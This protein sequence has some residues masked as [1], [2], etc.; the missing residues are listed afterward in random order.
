ML[1]LSSHEPFQVPME[2]FFIGEDDETKFLNSAYYT[3][4]SLGNFINKAKKISLVGKHLSYFTCRP[5]E[6]SSW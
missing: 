3:D 4:F 1:T 6:S 5:W 2:S